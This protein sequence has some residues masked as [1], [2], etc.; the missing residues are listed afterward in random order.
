MIDQDLR[1]GGNNHFQEYSQHFSDEAELSK[2]NLSQDS[3]RYSAPN[4]M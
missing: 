1:G 2:D 3:E 4:P